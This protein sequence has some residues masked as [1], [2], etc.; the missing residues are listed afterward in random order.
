MPEIRVE[1]P[2]DE[3]AVL[4]G[5]CSARGKGRT[6]VIR[7]LAK[8]WTGEKRHEAIV[9]CRTAGINPMGPESDRSPSG[10]GVK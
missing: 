10:K 2:D 9:I 8:D 6:D 4:D 7:G 5:Y 3:M 1:I